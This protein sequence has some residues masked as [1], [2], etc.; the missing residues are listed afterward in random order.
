MTPQPPHHSTGP[1]R[2][3]G[4]SSSNKPP[5]PPEEKLQPQAFIDWADAWL[6]AIAMH[7]VGIG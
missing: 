6:D 2:G 5:T 7:K 3:T 4:S 1:T